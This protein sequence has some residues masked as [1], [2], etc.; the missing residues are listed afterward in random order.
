M[1]IASHPLNPNKKIVTF[2]NAR[3]R[4]DFGF[5]APSFSMENLRTRLHQIPDLDSAI[6]WLGE[7]AQDAHNDFPYS[8]PVPDK[9][10]GH[11]AGKLLSSKAIVPEAVEKKSRMLQT[12]ISH[13]E[14]EG[15]TAEPALRSATA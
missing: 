12:I 14:S 1:D 7:V 2:E 10:L 5:V 13:Y 3:E 4:L 9:V 6:S 11:V 15:G 8:V